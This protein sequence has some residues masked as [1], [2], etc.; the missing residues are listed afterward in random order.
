M[1]AVKNIPFFIELTDG[2]GNSI[3]VKA[4]DISAVLRDEEGFTV[5]MLTT[6]G[7]NIIAVSETYE[8]VKALL[9]HALNGIN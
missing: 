6:F 3:L 7:E 9:A 1:T 8:Q 2:G 5:L 4:S